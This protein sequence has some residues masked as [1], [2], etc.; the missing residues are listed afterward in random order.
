[1]YFCNLELGYFSATAI[2]SFELI[3]KKVSPNKISKAEKMKEEGKLLSAIQPIMGSIRAMYPFV[4]SEM[5]ERAV[6]RPGPF[7][8]RFW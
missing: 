6:A 7:M 8:W 4:I 2:V 5:V 3:L 1:M